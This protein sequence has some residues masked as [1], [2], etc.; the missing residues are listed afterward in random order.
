MVSP[1]R[2]L[3]RF[4]RMWTGSS[5]SGWRCLE[6]RSVL[7]DEALD[8]VGPSVTDADQSDVTY[9]MMRCRAPDASIRGLLRVVRQFQLLA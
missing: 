2:R 9:P 5:S 6:L 4:I 8:K 7:L 3:F 1:H